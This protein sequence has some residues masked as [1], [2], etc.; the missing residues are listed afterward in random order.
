MKN[1]I[2]KYILFC[3]T[4]EDLPIFMQ[5]WWLDNVAWKWNWNVI[6][7]E[8]WWYIKAIFPYCKT[9]R[10]NIFKWLSS[11]KLTQ[12]LW[13]YIKYPKWQ[14]YSTRLSYEKKI[15]N[16]IIKQIP[17]YDYFD[18]SFSSDITNWLPFYWKWYKQTTRYSYVIDDISIENLEKDFETDIRRRRRKANKC[19]VRVL[20]SKDIKKFYELNKKTFIRQNIKIPYNFEFVNKLYNACLK[21]NS[22]KIYFAKDSDDNI[23]AG[24]L[25]VYDKNTVYYLMW[26]IDPN[27]KDLGGM[28]VVQFESIKFALKNNKKFDFEGSMIENIERYFRS[29][30]SIQKSY[31]RISKINSKLYL[32]LKYLSDLFKSV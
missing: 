32:T 15:L 17:K 22:C 1:N 14:K 13:P 16:E 12:F 28:D 11:P 5:Y 3:K 31:F 10:F 6:I 7:V 25:L 24:N 19:G 8:K 26:G 23:I 27:K 9:K 21:N 29:F 4:E 20:E 2:E 30:G 18:Q